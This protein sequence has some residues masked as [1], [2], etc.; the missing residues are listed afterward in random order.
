MS[1][2]TFNTGSKDSSKLRIHRRSTASNSEPS[3]VPRDYDPS[4][5]DD[6]RHVRLVP[7]VGSSFS[8]SD[9]VSPITPPDVGSTGDLAVLSGS[10]TAPGEEPDIASKAKSLAARCWTEDEEFLVK[11]KIAE[12]LGGK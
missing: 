11:E 2:G 6:S 12:W 5:R 3:L 7:S 9:T 4:G 1:S 10:D 8:R